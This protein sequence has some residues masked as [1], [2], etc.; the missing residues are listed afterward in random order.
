MKYNSDWSKTIAIDFDGVV[1]NMNKGWQDGKIYG[2]LVD[3]V[4][5]SI[6][7]LL[8]HGFIPIICTSREKLAPVRVWLKKKGLNIEVTNKKIPC[9]AIIDD[10]AIRFTN[11][12]D[13]KNLF[14]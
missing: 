11:W 6:T 12:N 2:E 9:L 3:E 4:L 10:R 13:I 1:H 5:E 8:K 14:I 7:E